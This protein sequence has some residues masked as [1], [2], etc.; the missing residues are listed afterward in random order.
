[1]AQ[2]SASGGR[3]QGRPPRSPGSSGQGSSGGRGGGSGRSAAGRSGKPPAST[4]GPKIGRSGKPPAS[5]GAPKSGRG[6]ATPP[7]RRAP[8]REERTGAQ[9][10]YDG[11]DLP[12]DITGRELDRSVAAQLQG[13]PEKLA[14]RVARHLV[15]AGRL[16]DDDPALAYAHAKA[17]RAR[18]SRLAVVREACGEAAYAAGEFAEAITE[19][20]A[21]RRMNGAQDYLPMIADC[22]RA[23]GR[24]ERAI[25]V[26]RDAGSRSLPEGVGV[27]LTIVEAGARRDL[28]DLPAALRTLEAAPL[29]SQSRAEWSVR[30]RYA[31]A[32]LL[33]AAG[34]EEE[35]A[36][37]FHRAAAI[38]SDGV[39]D[40]EERAQELDASRDDG[41]G[42]STAPD[43]D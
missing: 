38:D 41:S 39:T 33:V 24:P 23:L 30:L 5:T 36:E 1:M 6:G 27:E 17:A 10:A 34:R 19:L 29:H 11:P 31:Y 18:A 40:A 16:I 43:A 26:A 7:S 3:S 25:A 15:A 35:A 37:W 21:A 14:L 28:G 2:G 42:P 9:Q 32:D 4:G 8:D 12:A 22:E 13:L 20:R